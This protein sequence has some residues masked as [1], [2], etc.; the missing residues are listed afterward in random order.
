MLSKVAFEPLHRIGTDPAEIAGGE[1]RKEIET[2]IGRRCPVG[3]DRFRIFLEIVGRQMVIVGGDER[4]EET[5][6]PPC[7]FAQGFC[8]RF[9]D[10]QMSNGRR[11]PARPP[12]DH[13]RKR[14]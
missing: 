3:D 14:P 10:G 5:P 2:D 7:D 9:G 11:R 8:V 12:G 6:R 4:L 1:H 13:G